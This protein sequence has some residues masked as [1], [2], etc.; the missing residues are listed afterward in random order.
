MS[1]R[2]SL[3]LVNPETGEIEERDS[4]IADLEDKVE[5]YRKT[6]EKQAREIG[7]L[8]RR[9][10]EDEDPN[11]HPL[12]K[13]IVELIERWKRGAGHRK[14]KTSADRV[15]FVKARLKDGY[16]VEQI[17]LAIDGICA[18]PFVANGQRVPNGTASQRHDRLGIALGGGE[19]LEEFARLG[20]IARKQ[21][22]V[23]WEDE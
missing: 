1:A 10:T 12:G 6:C 4:Y 3:R 5:G 13:E 16:T 7:S 14:S 23:T 2:P 15:K 17:E 9:I 21:G 8:T 22:L 18:F 19:K 20:H 11:A